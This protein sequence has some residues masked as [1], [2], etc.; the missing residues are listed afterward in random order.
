M[1]ITNKLWETNNNHKMGCDGFVHIDIKGNKIPNRNDLESML[2]K[3]ATKDDSCNTITVQLYDM[4]FI[5]LKY[6]PECL[7]L[8]SHGMTAMQLCNILLNKYTWLT[9]DTEI[10]CYYYK[11]IKQ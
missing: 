7:A 8:A 9:F 5:P 1:I 3:I 4:H 2:F 11:K 6:L 10:A